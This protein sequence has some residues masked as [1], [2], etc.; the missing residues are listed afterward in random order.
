[1]L[2]TFIGS[3]LARTA[4]I[5]CNGNVLWLSLVVAFSALL[6]APVKPLLDSAIM[7]MLTDKSTYGKSRLFGQVGIGMGSFL[8][9]PL[10]S[11]NYKLMFL[12]QLLVAAPTAFLMTRFQPKQAVASS[13]PAVTSTGSTTT[14]AKK[15]RGMDVWQALKH[16]LKETKVLVFFLLVFIIGVSSGIIENFAY[17][18]LNQLPG[19]K[20]R[21]LGVMRLCSS[22]AGGPMF[23][24]SGEIIKWIGVNGVMNM[25]L[26]SYILRFAIYASVQNA[27]L[28]LPAEI[29]R[30]FSFAM[31]WSGATYYVYGISPKG[32]TATMVSVFCVLGCVVPIVVQYLTPRLCV[33]IDVVGVFERNVWGFRSIVRL[34]HWWVFKQTIWDQYDVCTMCH[35]GFGDFGNLLGL[36][37]D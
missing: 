29:L 25:S 1:M 36:S 14:S 4:L 27:W 16:T 34:S 2:L 15:P 31:F 26:L 22:L 32:L 13:A 30:G 23:W 20:G 33:C 8:V 3:I 35:G 6:N 11:T 24:I 37:T 7:S 10:L 18:R 28:A 19:A 9:G 12:A 17:V 5:W 21:T